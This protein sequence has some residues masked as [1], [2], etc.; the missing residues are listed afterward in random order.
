MTLA[1]YLAN[2]S[3]HS[4]EMITETYAIYAPVY[5]GFF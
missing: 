1:S 5:E 4:V 2:L 3:I